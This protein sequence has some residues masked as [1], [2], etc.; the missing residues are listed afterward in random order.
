MIGHRDFSVGIASR[1][2][3]LF[4][5]EHLQST[6]DPATL[7]R[8]IARQ[9]A[10]AY[11]SRVDC[12]SAFALHAAFLHNGDISGPDASLALHC[13]CYNTADINFLVKSASLIC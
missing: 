12:A 8:G 1:L 5:C 3:V 2:Q 11:C 13:Q 4:V 9:R 10:S 6:A 7:Q